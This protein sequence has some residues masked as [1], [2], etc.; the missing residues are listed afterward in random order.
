M[1]HI[2]E[3]ENSERLSK[4]EGD[5]LRNL[6]L[7]LRYILKHRYVMI[8]HKV[9]LRPEDLWL[10]TSGRS[11]G[12]K[13]VQQLIFQ[14]AEERKVPIQVATGLGAGHGFRSDLNISD[15]ALTRDSMGLA[16]LYL[17]YTLLSEA[18]KMRIG[19]A[20]I[21]LYKKQ[22]GDSL[23]EFSG[24]RPESRSAVNYKG[25]YYLYDGGLYLVGHTILTGYPRLTCVQPVAIEKPDHYLGMV[26]S[27]SREELVFHSWCFIKKTS[28]TLIRLAKEKYAMLGM[29][30]A[31]ELAKS[32]PDVLEFFNGRTVS[33]VPRPK[34]SHG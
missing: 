30:N 20:L 26:S 25:Y 19:V 3:I 13:L 8:A 15:E 28:K 14:Y 2:A 24:W 32:D 4:E 29:F 11:R 12:T 16:G 21:K 23:P 31:D 6:L 10:V 27:A 33:K 17:V 22:E 5:A 7:Y 1:R 18:P 34:D 9:D